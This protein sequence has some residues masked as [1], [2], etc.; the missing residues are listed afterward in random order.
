MKLD[1]IAGD[2]RL[3]AVVKERYN[4]S[5]DALDKGDKKLLNLGTAIIKDDDHCIRCGLCARRCPT[6]AITME[7]FWFE[8]EIQDEE[9]SSE[10]VAAAWPS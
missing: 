4:I 6:Q 2:E 5:L 9:S 10:K 7:A 8:E 1:K 3:K